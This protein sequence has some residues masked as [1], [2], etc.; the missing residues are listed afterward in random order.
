M[1]RE[2]ILSTAQRLTRVSHL[3]YCHPR[4]LTTA[5]RARLCRVTKRTIQRNPHDL[6]DMGIRLWEDEGNPPRHGIIEGHY[7]PASM[8]TAIRHLGHTL[9]LGDPICPAELVPEEL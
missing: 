2:I 5:E 6:E 1:I 4:G 9:A 7:L 3:I 8:F